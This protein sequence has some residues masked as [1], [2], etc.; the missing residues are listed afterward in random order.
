MAAIETVETHTQG[1]PTRVV[2]SGIGTIPG[3]TMFERREY[4]RANL[5]GLRRLLMEE[6]RGH[7]SMSGAILMPACDARADLGVLFIEVSGFLPM[8][9]HGSIGVCTAAID[10]KLVNVREPQTSIVLDTPAGL[11]SALV[12][13]ENG[14][15]IGVTLTNVPSFLL[16]RDEVLQVGD[17]GEFRF[18][19][20]YGGNFYAIVSAHDFGLELTLSEAPRIVSTG[21]RIMR[22][23]N[24]QHRF[25]HPLE[26]RIDELRHVLFT[27]PPTAANA[28]AKGTVVLHPGTL[29]RSPCGTGTSARMAQ[30]YFRGDQRLEETFVHE[31]I[32]GSCFTGT[33]TEEV[34]LLPGSRAVV[35]KIRGR[36]WVSGHGSW[37]LERDDP[38]PN[39]F[40]IPTA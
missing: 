10:Q 26:K 7:G 30:R 37:L 15:A 40:L 31:S 16:L 1:M 6:P 19:L 3:A 35:P 18:D 21:L 23:V 34:E 36:A 13:V 24:E 25:A 20:A 11:V 9:G 28:D 22:A 17:L 27:A 5:D 32:L 12:D 39:G 2:T 38:F 33:L 8:C 4:A 14:R 29:D